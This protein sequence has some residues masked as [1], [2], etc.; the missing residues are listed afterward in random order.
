[1]ALDFNND[2]LQELDFFG[3][4]G[5]GLDGYFGGKLKETPCLFTAHTPCHKANCI[6]DF[7]IASSCMTLIAF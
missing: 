5:V 7:E 3:P 6:L 4:N 2:P 1:M